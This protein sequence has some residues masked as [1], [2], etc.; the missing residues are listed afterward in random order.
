VT[1]PEFRRAPRTKHDSALELFNVQGQLLPAELQRLI[2]I[3]DTGAAFTSTR[4]F[5]KGAR[6]RGRVRR[7][8]HPV[9]DFT[10]RIVRKREHPTRANSILYAIEFDPPAR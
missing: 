8:G 9:L 3:S 6:I 4:D 7:F 1:P 10:G 5:A 2:D